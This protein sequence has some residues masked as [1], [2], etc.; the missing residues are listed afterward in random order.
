M[1][2]DNHSIHYLCPQTRQENAHDG[3]AFVSHNDIHGG[4]P[5]AALRLVGSNLTSSD[6]A[7]LE[8]RWIDPALADHAGI[9]RVDS[10]TGGEIIGRKSGNYAG[11][12]IP[13]FRPGSRQV[14]DYRLRRDQPDLSRLRD[15][16]AR[17]MYS[18]CRPGAG[19]PVGCSRW[20]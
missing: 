6:Y 20:E 10:L 5:A 18:G 13:Y 19:W 2:F 11:I 14:R 16:S 9:R 17:A 1:N 3:V 8:A 4:T 7:A 15:R 12:L